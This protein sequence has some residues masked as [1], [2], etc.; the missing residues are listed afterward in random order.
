VAPGALIK[1]ALN[2]TVQNYATNGVV[3]ATGVVTSATRYEDGDYSVLY[4]KP[5]MADVDRAVLHIQG[6]ATS[7]PELFGSMFTVV[8]EN[9]LT[10]E[11][12]VDSVEIG[13]DGLV[14]ITAVNYPVELMLSDIQGDAIVV[15]DT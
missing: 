3:A 7:Q 9:I 4:Y 5:G 8:S 15:E 2:Q 12:M 14:S 13:D 10:A 1:V 6:G 11:Y